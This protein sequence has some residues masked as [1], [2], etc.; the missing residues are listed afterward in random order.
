[1]L[2]YYG[3]TIHGAR[4][5]QRKIANPT[6][7]YPPGPYDLANAYIHTKLS[8]NHSKIASIRRDGWTDVPL[9][10]EQVKYAVLDVFQGFE[11]VRKC[12]Q[13]V[14]YNTRVNGPLGK[15]DHV[16][17]EQSICHI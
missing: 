1:M 15:F 14:G 17:N 16:V 12:F 11:I 7:N 4:D 9:T 13:L 6:R 5:V 3:I 2:E 10:F 8:K